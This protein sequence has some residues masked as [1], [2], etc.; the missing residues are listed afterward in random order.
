MFK[1][2]TMGKILQIKPSPFLPHSAAFEFSRQKITP[3]NQLC[4]GNYL[5][6]LNII[7]GLRSKSIGTKFN[8]DFL[9]VFWF[10]ELPEFVWFFEH[11]SS[12]S[13][14]RYLFWLSYAA[15]FDKLL[16]NRIYK[17]QQR[18][19]NLSWRNSK[20]KLSLLLEQVKVS[21]LSERSELQGAK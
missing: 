6:T 20:I 19:K 7:F 1:N 8:K 17:N 3:K 21:T 15:V 5:T 13:L 14:K 16:S 11:N 4:R 2:V 9:V 12:G 18:K 10:K